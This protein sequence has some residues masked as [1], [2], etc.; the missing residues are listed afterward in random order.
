MVRERVRD[1]A[2]QAVVEAGYPA[3]MQRFVYKPLLEHLSERFL[4][5]EALAFAEG[6]ALYRV[7]QN[8]NQLEAQLFRRPDI[9]GGMVEYAGS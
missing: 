6:E 8:L 3:Q 9:V 5:G 4:D 7:G 2:E 1:I